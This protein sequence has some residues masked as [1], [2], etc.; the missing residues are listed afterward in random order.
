MATKCLI[1]P[2]LDKM[3]EIYRD[4]GMTEDKIEAEVSTLTEWMRKQPHLP[5]PTGKSM[6]LTLL[7][8]SK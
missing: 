7:I 3:N 6:H 8:I 2:S 4:L 5:D 1:L